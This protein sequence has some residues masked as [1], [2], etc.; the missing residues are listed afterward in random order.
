MASCRSFV[1]SCRLFPLRSS[2]LP[3][4]F[5]ATTLYLWA[6]RMPRRKQRAVLSAGAVFST[7]SPENAPM[8]S[9]TAPG[10][11]NRTK[12]MPKCTQRGYPGVPWASF[13]SLVGCPV[14]SLGARWRPR[15]GLL[16][17]L[18]GLLGVSWCVLG[19]SSAVLGHFGTKM[20]PKWSQ[21]E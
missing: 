3:W 1:A 20:D 6:V 2:L 13:G 12:V 9:Q 7:G 17:A 14:G 18:W 10:T 5:V 8:T 16:A 4:T 15:E 21:I 11:P 19:G